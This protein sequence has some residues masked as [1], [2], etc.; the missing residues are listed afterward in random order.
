VLPGVYELAQMGLLPEGMYRNRHFAEPTARAAQHVT[1]AAQDILYDPQTSGGLLL[2]VAER[3]APAL[4]R[5]LQDSLPCAAIV[6]YVKEN[7]GAAVE[8]I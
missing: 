1:R 2:A 4:L 8:I 7:S 3:D 6:G 5:A